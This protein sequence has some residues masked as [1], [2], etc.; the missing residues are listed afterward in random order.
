[1]SKKETAVVGLL[2][3]LAI[4]AFIGMQYLKAL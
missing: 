4:A 2:V 3:I 1:M